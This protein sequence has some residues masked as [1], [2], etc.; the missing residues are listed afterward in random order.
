[1]M[2]SS[3]EKRVLEV[4]KNHLSAVPFLQFSL[5]QDVKGRENGAAAGRV[6]DAVLHLRLPVGDVMAAVVFKNTGE[7]GNVRLGAQQLSEWRNLFV[8]DFLALPKAPQFSLPY[9][10]LTA[11]YISPRGAQLCRELGIGFCDL[12]GN[13]FLCFGQVFISRE[14]WP[15]PA[16]RTVTASLWATKS[17][18]VLRVLLE[19]PARVWKTQDLAGEAKVSTGLVSGVRSQLADREWI[20]SGDGGFCLR[21]PLTLLQE[22]TGQRKLKR[23]N[24]RLFYSLEKMGDIE[25]QFARWGEEHGQKVAL[26]EYSGAAR[27]APY[28]RY[29]RMWRGTLQHCGVIWICGQPVAAPMCACSCRATRACSMGR[30]LSRKR[31]LLLGADDRP[32]GT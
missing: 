21:E 18:R 28:S 7:V 25:K 32:S 31:Q 1:M 4:L 17:E 20:R 23:A 19:N 15:N 10:I 29:A 12:A 22:W 9:G 5:G 14:N 27:L 24:V 8:R 2:K 26:S 11:P 16:K 30:G 3:D 13:C 6:W